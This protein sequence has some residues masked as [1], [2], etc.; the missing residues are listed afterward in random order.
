METAG[1]HFPAVSMSY[2]SQNFRLFL[3][4]NVS[5]LNF[6]IFLFMY[7]GPETRSAVWSRAQLS[8]SIL[9]CSGRSASRSPAHGKLDVEDRMER[10]KGGGGK[11][12]QRKVAGQWVGAI[13]F[14]RYSAL[15]QRGNSCRRPRTKVARRAA[16]FRHRPCGVL[17]GWSGVGGPQGR[18]QIRRNSS[19]RT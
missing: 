2:I 16:A 19:G 6:R 14:D 12:G 4:S 11:R 18:G 7:P 15:R 10:G 13:G 3:V 9:L 5:V 1:S 17:T 8:R